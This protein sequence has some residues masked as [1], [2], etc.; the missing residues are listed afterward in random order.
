MRVSAIARIRS[1]AISST[2]VPAQPAER[3]PVDR[4]PRVAPG[5]RARRR[6]R[7]PARRPRWVTGMPAAAGTAIALVMPGTTSTGMPGARR[8]ASTSS[9]PRPKTNGS[10]PLSRTTNLPGQ[11]VLDQG[12]VD[13][14]P[15]PSTARTGSS[16]RRSPRRRRPAR[17]AARRGASRSVTTTSAWASS[18]PAA[19]GDQPGVAGA[20]AD[21]R[22]AG[23][24]FAAASA[25]AFEGAVGE[26]LDDARRGR[27]RRDAGRRRRAPPTVSSPTRPLAG[28]QARGRLRRRR[29]GRTRCAAP[30][31]RRATAALTV[32]SSVHGQHEP[33]AVAVA[34]AV[35]APL[36]GERARRATRPSSAGVTSGET[37]TTSAPAASRRHAALGH[38]PPP[39]TRTRRPSRR[40]PSRYGGTTVSRVGRTR[41]RPPMVRQP[42]ESAV[43]VLGPG[44]AFSVTPA[45]S[46][47]A[48]S[49]SDASGALHQRQGEQRAGALA[50]AEFQVDQ[51]TQPEV[52]QRDRVARLGRAVPGHAEVADGRGERRGDQRRGAGDHAVEDHRDAAAAP[53]R[54]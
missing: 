42:P 47:V 49:R 17:R 52:P 45:E 29:R 22:D 38:R 28:V 10:P 20:A 21:Q 27:P 5:R 44:H 43:K 48:T 26:P 12:R 7:T 14:A 33:G 8:S 6:R 32:A 18:L 13:R 9:P 31:P 24:G 54:A 11:R 36:P 34:G 3:R 53:H 37:S 25:R 41:C 40:R 30:R 35:G 15:A 39:T 16:P 19:D 46:N 51:R 1:T 2:R 50:E 23:T 4:R